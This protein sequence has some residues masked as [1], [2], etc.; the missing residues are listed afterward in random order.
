MTRKVNDETIDLI[1]WFEG[2]RL[3]AYR[4]PAGIPTIGYGHTKNVKMGT[5]ITKKQAL[6]LL[7]EDLTTF[8]DAVGRLVKVP[9]TD[10]QFGA[11]VAFT[12]NV[13][14]GAFS[15]STLLRLLNQKKY[16]LV[17][18]QLM[19]WNRAGGRV[20]LGLTRRRRAEADLWNKPEKE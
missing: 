14:E 8:E 9:L 10:N 12:F 11:L 1:T 17:P 5:I 20:L 7:R 16:D 3:K 15:R 4:C 19:K 6:D 13:G 18:E 2:L